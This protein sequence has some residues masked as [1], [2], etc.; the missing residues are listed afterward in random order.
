MKIFYFIATFFFLTCCVATSVSSMIGNTFLH[1]LEV[2][3]YEFNLKNLESVQSFSQNNPLLNDD[4]ENATEIVSTGENII[5]SDIHETICINSSNEGAGPAL[6]DP[7]NI[8]DPSLVPYF[9]ECATSKPL[10]QSAAG[11][12]FSFTTDDQAVRFDVSLIHETSSEISLAIFEEVAG[13]EGEL[14]VRICE[15]AFPGSGEINFKDYGISPNTRY[16]ILISGPDS[17]A[18]DFQLCINV[19]PEKI[20]DTNAPYYYNHADVF[21]SLNPL[22][23]YCLLMGPPIMAFSWPGC[24]FCCAFH[25][26]QWFVFV[27][28]DTSGQFKIEVDISKCMN[29]Q[30]AQLALYQL[31]CDTDFDP[32]GMSEGIQ[33]IPDMLVSDCN[34]ASSPQNGVIKFEVDNVE[35][36]SLFGMVI[37]GWANDA[38]RIDIL[39]VNPNTDAPDLSAQELST[40]QYIASP[41]F[42]EDTLCLGAIDVGFYI[43]EGVVGACSYNWYMTNMETNEVT[44][45]AGNSLSSDTLYLDFPQE[46]TFEVCV[47]ADNICSSTPPSCRAISI[48]PRDLILENP[49]NLTVYQGRNARF[50][51]ETHSQVTGYQWQADFGSGFEDLTE[52]FPFFGVNSSSLLIRDVELDFDSLMIRCLVFDNECNQ[53]SEVAILTV[54]PQYPEDVVHCSAGATAV[55]DVVNPVTGQIWMDRNLGAQRT[56]NFSRDRRAYGDLYQ[57]GRFSD[58]HQCRNSSDTTELA[59]INRPEYGNFII[60]GDFPQDWRTI[61]TNDLWDGINAENNP[62]P[63]GFRIPTLA[64]W[65]EERSSWAINSGSGAINSSLRLPLAGSRQAATGQ[66]SMTEQMGYYWSSSVSGQRSA[67]LVF[68][69]NFAF[70]RFASRA[71]GYSVRCIKEEVPV[72]DNDIEYKLEKNDGR[73]QPTDNPLDAILSVSPNPAKDYLNVEVIGGKSFASYN[74]ILY[75]SFGQEMIDKQNW[76][77]GVKID[78]S[79]LHPGIYFLRVQSKDFSFA[80]IVSVVIH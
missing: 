42:G 67:V 71:T 21:C 78:V 16:F 66:L 6:Y 38:C 68:T 1:Y 59:E 28:G 24:E 17:T 65:N 58:G 54:N 19:K 73:F 12:W 74:L 29:N 2:D 27:A 14:I 26:P 47:I 44:S 36:G 10:S 18:G 30:G 70:S 80:K 25:N 8:S 15:I 45:L 53:I 49:A 50:S 41:G 11:V 34:L 35:V 32:S 3:N 46:G 56:A 75:N 60:S 23:E 51:V 5:I 37:D 9:S 20:C 31:P 77:A 72:T 4:C 61:Q 55:V 48:V 39:E 76:K 79:D 62:C 52:D 64:E 40:P 7:D 22:M 33:P 69:D 57:W 13:C 43:T 63:G